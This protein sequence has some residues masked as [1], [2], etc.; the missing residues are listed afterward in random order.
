MVNYTT[1]TYSD[2]VSAVSNT[3]ADADNVER[4]YSMAS[5]LTGIDHD[6]KVRAMNEHF[7]ED[8][9]IRVWLQGAQLVNGAA[10]TTS[11]KGTRLMRQWSLSM[12]IDIMVRRNNIA[13]DLPTM[14]ATLDSV[15]EKFANQ[16]G[17][18]YFGLTAVKAF[19]WEWL[20][21]SEF[22]Y[23]SADY[24]LAEGALSIQVY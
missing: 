15:D 22:V 9:F 8:V 10:R 1:V 13:D 21:P 24:V 6:M 3:L 19:S 20:L 5:S 23:A 14:L 4:V 16:T 17:P 12:E 7:P 11:N 18:G 2:I